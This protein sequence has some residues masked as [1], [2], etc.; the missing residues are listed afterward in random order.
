MA[1]I[2]D[3]TTLGT[4]YRACGAKVRIKSDIKL[5]KFVCYKGQV[6]SFSIQKSLQL[7]GAVI[8]WDLDN[9]I[10]FLRIRDLFKQKPKDI[11]ETDNT[12]S[13]KSKFLERHF[14]PEAYSY[15][16]SGSLTFGGKKSS[17]TIFQTDC[18]LGELNNLGT[19][20]L[21][22]KEL[23]T[24]FNAEINAGDLIRIVD[25]DFV[26]ITAVHAFSKSEGGNIQVSKFWLG[27][28]RSKQ[29]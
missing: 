11:L 8:V 13:L 24:S 20:L 3:S 1:V 2:E 28:L 9:G 25:A 26:V 22:S 19:Y 17:A 16:S 15:N 27:E 29:S 10:S 4:V 14:V 6:P 21:Q 18:D 23:T 5:N 12:K 7:S